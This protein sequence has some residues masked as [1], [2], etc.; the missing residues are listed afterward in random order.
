L[1]SAVSFLPA[2]R[3]EMTEAHNWYERRSPGLGDAFLA[4]VDRQVNRI[5]EN[6]LQFPTILS[7]VRRARLQRFPYGLF[8]RMLEDGAFVIACFHAN[9]DPR[10]WRDRA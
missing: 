9:R 2:A 6:P 5:A 1:K 7:D 8:F 3:I 4:E 10:I